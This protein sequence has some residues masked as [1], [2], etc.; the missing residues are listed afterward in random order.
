[1]VSGIKVY[2]IKDFMG[3]TEAGDIDLKR[4]KQLITELVKVAGEHANDNILI[5]LRETAVSIN[6]VED[7]IKVALEIGSF[8][9]AFKNKIA[10]VVPED[11]ER[12]AIAYQMEACMDIQGF[13]YQIFTDYQKAI[14]WLSK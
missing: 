7:V 8:R 1:M 9:S 10:N 4:S 6:T 12:S 13:K 3:K 2:R 11:K 5:D 14:D